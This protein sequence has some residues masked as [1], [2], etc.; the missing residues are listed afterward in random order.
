MMNEVKGLIVKIF[1][2]TRNR[3]RYISPLRKACKIG[4][5]VGMEYIPAEDFLKN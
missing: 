4:D 5:C 2:I 1:K 3:L